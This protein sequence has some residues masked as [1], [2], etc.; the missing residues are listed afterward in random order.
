[1]N[2]FWTSF[3]EHA[4]SHSIER[5][6][7]P[8]EKSE[9]DS[10]LNAEAESDVTLTVD[11]LAAKMQQ[12]VF[13]CR[14]ESFLQTEQQL[15]GI[16][17]YEQ[18]IERTYFHF[19]LPNPVQIANWSEYL[20][21]I[22]K[23][24]DFDRTVHL[25]ERALIPL[26]LL[27][28]LWARYANFLVRH[29]AADRAAEL[30]RRGE[31]SPVSQTV[32]FQRLRGLFE[33]SMNAFDASAEIHARLEGVTAA[34]AQITVVYH[35][36]REG[37]RTGDFDRMKARAHE[38]L[39]NFLMATSNPA[40]YTAAAAVLYRVMRE[41]DLEVLQGTCTALSLA[42]ALGVRA[43]I[44]SEMPERAKELFEHFLYSEESCLSPADRAKVLPVF[45]NFLRK[46]GGTVVEIRRA[47]RL[48]LSL[49]R[50]LRAKML[51]DRRELT[52]DTANSAEILDRWMKYLQGRD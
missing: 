14:R 44:D 27:P 46:G 25:Y 40:E 21:L 28:A 13:A 12:M 22:E 30:W 45:I 11:M 50:L 42:L 9:I 10:K 35:L 24:G 51:E 26:N 33:E 32:E 1:L 31:S 8:Q 29:G 6:A 43:L 36:L 34:D 23:F 19:K 18:K 20:A 37:S 15:A 39:S 47:E 48:A 49:E 38:I 7:T 52:K 5:A 2:T 3:C 41:V 17:M 4:K 16:A